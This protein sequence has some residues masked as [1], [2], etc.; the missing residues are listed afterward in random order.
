MPPGAVGRFA[1]VKLWP[2]IKTAEDECIARLKLAAAAL[3]VE[4]IEVLADGTVLSGG[5]G[6]VSRSNVDFVI[7]LHYDTPKLYDAFSFVALW[8]PLKFYHEWGY[9]RCSRN[10]TTHD[11]FLSCS[12]QAADDHVARMVRSAGTHLAPHFRLYHSTP[13]IVHEPSLGEGKLF[14]AGINWE[15]INGGKSRHQEVLK[16]L[17]GTGLLRIYGPRVFQG[18]KVWDGYQSYVREVPFDGVSMLDEIS[19]AGIALVLSS[20]A[21]KESG[22]MSNRL[23][24]SVAAGVLVICDE[25]P[26]ARRFFGDSLLYIDSRASAEQIVADVTRHVEWARRYPEQVLAMI[27]RAQAIFRERFTLIGNLRTLYDGF[28]E[29]KAALA[30][31][32][33]AD[34]QARV[35]VKLFMLMP[36]YSESQLREHIDSVRVQDYGALEPVLVVDQRATELFAGDIAAQAALSSGPLAVRGVTFTET[37][38]GSG[39]GRRRR[40]GEVILELIRDLDTE[41]FAF[42]APNE[43]LFSNHV[44]TLVAALQRNPATACA[45]TAAILKNGTAP[46]HHVHELIDFGHVDRAGPPGY[47]R[48]LFRTAAVREDAALALPYLDGRPL[49]VL[50]ADNDVEQQLAA[51]IVIDVAQEFPPRTWDEAAENE[52]IRDYAPEAFRHRCGFGPRP[53]PY[54]ARVGDEPAQQP[55]ALPVTRLSQLFRRSLNPRWLAMQW[56][57]IRSSGLKSRLQLLKARLAS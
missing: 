30:A 49:A 24:E 21:H 28:A 29:R 44:S 16:R 40:L 13:D 51:T 57:L 45:A 46:I 10:L 41:A 23:F 54:A 11:D 50:V 52:V 7:H 19:R 18:V 39:I 27:A 5:G 42:V 53:V 56:R 32:A 36:E 55:A 20:A 25:N 8:N 22:L 48:F 3:G 9:Q 33:S 34:G 26:F 17:D 1:V 35:R 14:Y 43:R 12:S 2:E 38:S 31:R 6:R 47:G 15:A 4:C 37:E